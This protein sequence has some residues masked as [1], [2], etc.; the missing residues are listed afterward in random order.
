MQGIGLAG[1][2]EP[3]AGTTVA[4]P[5]CHIVLLLFRPGVGE[6]EA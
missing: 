2:A 6:D 4:Q 1:L 3:D 5:N